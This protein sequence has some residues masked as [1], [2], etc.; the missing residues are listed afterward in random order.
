MSDSNVAE[1]EFGKLRKIFFPIHAFEVKKA[2]PMG[3]MFFFILFNYTCM[4][5]IKDAMII[6]APNS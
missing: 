1:P 5:N 4:H 6:N 3:I 2:L